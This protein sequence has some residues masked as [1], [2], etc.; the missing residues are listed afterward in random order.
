MSNEN[1][2]SAFVF[3]VQNGLLAV[4]D[5]RAFVTPEGFRHYGAL[6]SMLYATN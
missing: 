4:Q 1:I 2:K 3:L 6:S 5:G